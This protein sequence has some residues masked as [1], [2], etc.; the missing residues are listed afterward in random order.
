MI[1]VTD[2]NSDSY[3]QEHNVLPPKSQFCDI[4][5]E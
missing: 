4:S 2:D 1:I 5:A 3:H